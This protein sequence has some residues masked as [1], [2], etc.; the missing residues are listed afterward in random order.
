MTLSQ[1][2]KYVLSLPLE[3]KAWLAIFLVGSLITWLA[4]RIVPMRKLSSY[5]GHHLEN[6]TVC[7]PAKKEH[8]LTALR[9]GQLMSM[10]GN[11]IPWKSKCLSQALCV[12]WLLNRYNISSVFY[13]G[14]AFELDQTVGM[15][16]HAWVDA[17][18]HTVI[19]GPQ[20][21]KYKVVATF[22]TPKLA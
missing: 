18:K 8:V 5:M 7:I 6:R 14:A 16:A 13:L 10:V 3:K 11:S 2:T 4:I 12:K 17:D 1:K 15:K 20:H 9:M 22:T 19:G 21:E